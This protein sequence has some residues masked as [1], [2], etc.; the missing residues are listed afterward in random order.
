MINKKEF[1]LLTK[2]EKRVEICKD[3]IARLKAQTILPHEGSFMYTYL[4]QNEQNSMQV[5]INSKPC[6]VCAKGALFCSWVGNFNE[7]TQT[8]FYDESSLEEVQNLKVIV[9]EL[10]KIFGKKMLDRI[11]AVFEQESYGWHFDSEDTEKY[12]DAFPEWELMD[13]M[14]YIVK[15]KGTFPLPD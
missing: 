7:V 8:Q 11:E 4:P 6:S 9:P 13:I 10:V 15:N 12:V 2:K 14:K 1:D 5:A 3:V